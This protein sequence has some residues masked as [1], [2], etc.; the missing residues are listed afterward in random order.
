M[1]W[2]HSLDPVALSLGP[3]TIYWYGLV[4]AAGFLFLYWY[5]ANYSDLDGSAVDDYIVW[6]VL[7]MLLGSRLFTFLFW[8]P[9]Q[10]L[11]NPLSF[12]AIWQGGMSFHGGFAGMVAATYFFTRQRDISFY[13]VADRVSVPAGVFLGLGRLANL[14]NAELVGTPFQGSW[15]VDYTPQQMRR[16]GLPDVCRHP[17]QVYAALKN[18]VITPFLLA[19]KTINTMPQGTIF[20]AFTAAYNVGRVAVDVFRQEPSVLIGLSTGQTLSI[21]F[22]AV[23]SYMLVHVLS[24]DG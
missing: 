21:V 15:C 14:V 9:S 13:S 19:L 7:G 24:S 22:A 16:Q 18:A 11:N 1:A 3:L 12:F 23:S 2:Q 17:Y 6:S 20:W 4:Y 10:L 5:L 8:Y